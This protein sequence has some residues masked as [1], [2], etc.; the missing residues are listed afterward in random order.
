VD[1]LRFFGGFAALGDGNVDF[2]DPF[3]FA[4]VQEGRGGV[5]SLEDGGAFP[6]PEAVVFGASR[7]SGEKDC[8]EKEP[9]P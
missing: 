8:G 4:E 6:D 2:R 5:G 9:A 7:Q 1:Q 3:G